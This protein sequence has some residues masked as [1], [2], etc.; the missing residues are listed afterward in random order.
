MHLFI[1]FFLRIYHA[2][3]KERLGNMYAC[4]LYTWD[5]SKNGNHTVTVTQQKIV[6]C[7]RLKHG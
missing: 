7:G 2:S 5:V 3:E 1:T 6:V 4:I